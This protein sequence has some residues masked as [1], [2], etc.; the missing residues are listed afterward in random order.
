DFADPQQIQNVIIGGAGTSSE[1]TF[2]PKAFTYFASQDLLALPIEHFGQIFFDDVDFVEDGDFGGPGGEAVPLQTPTP[3]FDES[4]EFQGLYVYRVTP[5]QGF[6]YLGRISTWLDDVSFWWTSFTRGV[7]IA[8]HVYAVTERA[9]ISAPTANVDAVSG[10][11]VLP[12]P[13][14][15]GE[16]I[17]PGEPVVEP[18]TPPE[19]DIATSGVSESGPDDAGR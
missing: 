17:K 13:I 18:D 16:P 3:S 6:D 1:A 11:V 15:F 19:P 7:F 9:V 8:D 5:D 10:S 14:G 4:E 2:N 12:E